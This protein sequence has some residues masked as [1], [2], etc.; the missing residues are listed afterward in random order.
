MMDATGHHIKIGHDL[1]TIGRETRRLM[2]R[3]RGYRNRSGD[4]R[5]PIAER[6]VA[7]QQ[8]GRGQA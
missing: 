6:R 8:I 5:L 3:L 4:R 1:Q 7:G 2:G